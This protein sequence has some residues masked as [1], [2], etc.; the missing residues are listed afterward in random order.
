MGTRERKEARMARRAEWAE[1]AKAESDRRFQAAHTIADGIPMGQP[2]LVSHHSERHARRD[3]ERIHSNM[4][5]GVEASD[6]AKH[7]ASVAGGIAHQLDRSIFSDDQNAIEAL[8]ARIQQHEAERESMKRVNA[9]WRNAGKP[10]ACPESEAEVAAH[11]EVWSSIG[12]ACGMK[13]SELCKLL[14]R[15]ILTPYHPQPFP[16]YAMQNLGGRITADRK[17]IEDI[18]ARAKRAENA[19]LAGGVLIEGGSEYITVT[20]AE[21]PERNVIEALKAAGFHWGSGRW[22]G[23][24]ARL[25]AEVIEA[26]QPAPQEG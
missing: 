17:R 10:K 6:R 12:A 25:P 7:H 18:Q 9:A 22:L 24:R 8:E 14:R 11:T 23:Y 5:R 20:F 26:T 15:M 1:K 4:S 13:E 19:E 16:G 3:Q 2:I 21:K